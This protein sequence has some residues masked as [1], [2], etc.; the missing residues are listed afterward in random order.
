MRKTNLCL[1]LT[2]IILLSLVVICD[3]T[4]SYYADHADQIP[5]PLEQNIVAP[6]CIGVLKFTKNKELAAKQLFAEYHYSV[7]L[8]G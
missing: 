8:P 3:V 5:L 2:I 4:A 6:I 1:L 7:K